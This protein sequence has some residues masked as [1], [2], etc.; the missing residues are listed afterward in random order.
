MEYCEAGSVMDL[1][2]TCRITLTEAEIASC[3]RDAISGLAYLHKRHVIHRDVKG[4]NL[5]LTA[6]GECKL[7]DFGVSKQ[8]VHTLAR[9]KTLIGTPYWMAP[10]IVDSKARKAGGYNAKADIWSLGITAIEAAQGRPPLHDV[11]PMKAIFLIP[12]NPPPRLQDEEEWSDAFVSFLKSSLTKDFKSRPSASELL[13][14]PFIKSAPDQKVVAQLVQRCMP[15]IETVRKLRAERGESDSDE[16]SVSSSDRDRTTGTLFDT[17]V[18]T[19][20]TNETE[21]TLDGTDTIQTIQTVQ[22][23][24]GTVVEPQYIKAMRLREEKEV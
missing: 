23:A 12:K 3:M 9:T 8:L 22:R 5:L 18:Q 24:T 7:A 21:Q 16:S 20:S 11:F 13:L 19:V 10:E 6:R 1:M 14:H 17:M 4:A 15:Q 2:L